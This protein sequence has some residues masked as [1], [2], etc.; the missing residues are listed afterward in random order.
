MRRSN[1]ILIVAALALPAAAQTLP[2]QVKD[3][4][5]GP[6]WN[7]V[8]YF[9]PSMNAVYDEIEA[10]V[11]GALHATLA[12]LIAT[13]PGANE[14][15]Y[16]TAPGTSAALTTAA[17]GRSLLAATD[18]LDFAEIAQQN[19]MVSVFWYG[20]KGDG[21]TDDTTAIQAGIDAVKGLH[22]SDTGTGGTLVFPPGVFLADT[23]TFQ[24]LQ[25]LT[26]LG[27]HSPYSQDHHYGTIIKS[28]SAQNAL[29]Y[30]EGETT[31]LNLVGFAFD[32]QA[33]CRDVVRVTGTTG[34]QCSMNSIR[35]CSF[36][37]VDNDGNL[38][39]YATAGA[40][41][42]ETSMWTVSDCI[43]QLNGLVVPTDVG[44]AINWDNLG[45]YGHRVNNCRFYGQSGGHTL[46]GRAGQAHITNCEW[47]NNTTAGT[48]DIE[49]NPTEFDLHIDKSNSFSRAN[50][51]RSNPDDIAETQSAYL[52]GLI[53]TDSLHHSYGSRTETYSIEQDGT[54]PVSLKDFRGYGIHTG[55]QPTELVVDR[56]Q[57][58]YQTNRVADYLVQQ[59]PNATDDALALLSNDRTAHLTSRHDTAS[60]RFVWTSYEPGVGYY[61]M[62]WVGSAFSWVVGAATVTMP[63]RTGTVARTNDAAPRITVV[64]DGNW[65]SECLRIWQAP[66]DYAITIDRIDAYVM[67]NTSPELVYNIEE[68]AATTPNVAG[69]D[70]YASDQV[71]DA[72]GE[73][74]TVFSNASIAAGAHLVLTT[75]ASPDTGTVDA[76]LLTIY[77]H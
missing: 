53:V 15:V 4:P 13:D 77:Y 22:A 55:G 60:G 39:S 49:W 24:D 9:S 7:G 28:K 47:D 40:T 2:P 69:V 50:F 43:F 72:D 41:W 73:T 27:Q 56:K 54:S 58:K 5:Y 18:V 67:G 1:A 76:L 30:I 48:C 74:E 65:D 70:V 12:D 33:Q 57:L 36:W 20:A 26:L 6:S 71:A 52:P 10:I 44:T 63:A 64:S 59:G 3:T 35:S 75:G 61:P 34:D 8:R 42:V 62:G 17:Y 66:Y 11:V 37:N 31:T 51:I 19:H 38:L 25:C 23:L 29:I 21:V 46:R 68:R 14:M 32:G 45:A 16:W